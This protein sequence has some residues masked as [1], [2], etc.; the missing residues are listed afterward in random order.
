MLW[1]EGSHSQLPA[2]PAGQLAQLFEADLFA[3]FVRHRHLQR[4]VDCFAQN[5]VVGAPLLVVPE[6]AKDRLTFTTITVQS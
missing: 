3:R 6:P 1:R 4:G 2:K 5:E